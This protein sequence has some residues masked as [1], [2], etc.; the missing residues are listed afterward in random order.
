MRLCLRARQG[1]QGPG[2][3]FELRE[4]ERDRVAAVVRAVTPQFRSARLFLAVGHALTYDR[5]WREPI[6]LSVAADHKVV[7]EGLSTSILPAR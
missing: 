1:V 3:T 4:G 2:K 7:F 5:I 6:A